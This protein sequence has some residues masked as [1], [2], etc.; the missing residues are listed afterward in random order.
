MR[1]AVRR[2]VCGGRFSATYV[3]RWYCSVPDRRG[4]RGRPTSRRPAT[5][6][7]TS[8]S[9]ET[10]VRGTT[11]TAPS[12]SATTPMMARSSGHCR[13]A[14]QIHCRTM[15]PVL[16]LLCADGCHAVSDPLGDAISSVRAVRRQTGLPQGD[17]TPTADGRRQTADGN[18]HP[19][20]TVRNM[21]DYRYCCTCFEFFCVTT[22]FAPHLTPMYSTAL[23]HHEVGGAGERLWELSRR[24]PA[25]RDGAGAWSL[26]LGRC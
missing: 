13:L 5:S 20:R 15:D 6:T 12:E 9:K 11:L 7:M 19:A 1:L 14:S 4:T 26:A 16:S 10:D 17:S 2:V 23:T 25:A 8:A 24:R 18:E 21:Q 22:A 3:R